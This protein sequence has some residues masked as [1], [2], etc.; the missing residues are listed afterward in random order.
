VIRIIRDPRSTA[1]SLTVVPFGSP[2]ILVTA[3]SL[4]PGQRAADKYRDR[5]LTVRLEDLL[6]DGRA[7]M[8]RALDFVGEPWD[9][10]VLDHS[11]RVADLNDMPPHPWLHGAKRERKAVVATW[12]S[13]SPAQV[14]L[15]EWLTRRSM[16][17]GGYEPARFYSEPG[18]LALW[19]EFFRHVPELWRVVRVLARVSWAYVL[20]GEKRANQT[21]FSHLNPGSW[22]RY[23]DPPPRENAQ[24]RVG[25]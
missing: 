16:Q 18:R 17:E 15:V 5:I 9:D 14:R 4:R 13:R 2:S 3:L 23:S 20:H 11:R 21:L 19:A 10:A 12:Q 25:A 22:E 1:E 8:K 6:A 7:V 24:P